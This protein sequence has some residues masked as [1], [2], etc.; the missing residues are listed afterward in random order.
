M[1]RVS[2]TEVKEVFITDLTASAIDPLIIAANLF[3]TAKLSSQGLSTELL[4]EIERYLTAHL[5]SSLAGREEGVAGTVISEG[6]GSANRTYKSL[7][8]SIFGVLSS[9][10]YGMIAISLDTSNTL[11]KIGKRS[12]FIRTIDIA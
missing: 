3:V 10:P 9:T 6:A 7:D 12:S 11:L 2:G 4:K 1:G 5:I 8:L